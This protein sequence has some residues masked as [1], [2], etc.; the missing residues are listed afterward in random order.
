M[1]TSTHPPHLPHELEDAAIII[2][3]IDMVYPNGR[4]EATFV[5]CTECK[6]K[7]CPDC[8]G[9]CPEFP[10]HDIQ[11]MVK[12]CDIKAKAMLTSG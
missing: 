9:K 2:R 11:C 6:E 5:R 1:I 7:V 4:D 8:A 12:L 10:C 3:K